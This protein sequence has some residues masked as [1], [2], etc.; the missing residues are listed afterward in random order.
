MTIVGSALRVGAVPGTFASTAQKSLIQFAY[1][2]ER[3]INTAGL[4]Q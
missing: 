1:M 3:R 2:G 4:V